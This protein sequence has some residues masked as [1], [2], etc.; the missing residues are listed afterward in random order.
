MGWSHSFLTRE[1]RESRFPV[2]E[3]L[4][5][6]RAIWNEREISGICNKRIY[7]LFRGPSELQLNPK[8]IWLEFD[9]A[10]SL[11][12]FFPA[13]FHTNTHTQ[14]EHAE[15]GLS[16]PKVKP[17]GA[18]RR[19]RVLLKAVLCVVANVK[20][21]CQLLRLH[22]KK[23]PLPTPPA[24]SSTSPPFD[25][26]GFDR[27]R[28]GGVEAGK[29]RVEEKASQCSIYTSLTFCLNIDGITFNKTARAYAHTS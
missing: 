27:E 25:G 23:V 26:C 24:I 15:A 9:F 19:A 16:V 13:P 17:A 29:G 18:V 22:E 4:R 7:C 3:M 8:K 11:F 6:I 10:A 1:T 28:G 20:Y 2:L 12:I 21:A 14:D 5:I